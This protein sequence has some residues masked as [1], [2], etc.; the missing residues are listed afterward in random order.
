MVVPVALGTL[1]D[2]RWLLSWS[3]ALLRGAWGPSAP[4][5]QS[6]TRCTAQ[7][8][9]TSEINGMG[10]KRTGRALRGHC[11]EGMVEV[12]GRMMVDG[13]GDSDAV[14]ALQKSVCVSWINR[15]FPERCA[16]FDE[17]RWRVLSRNIP[18]QPMHF[19]IDRFE[20]PNRR[21]A[22]PWILVNWNEAKVIC[23]REAKRLCTEAESRP[24]RDVISTTGVLYGRGA[25]AH[26]KCR[27]SADELKH[28]RHRQTSNWTPSCRLSGR[29]CTGPERSV[30]GGRRRRSEP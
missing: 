5:L 8:P 29:R 6:A 30:L 11:A 4:A 15:T 16:Q 1:T 3:A 28:P 19:C 12:E 14:D 24:R 22:Y 26:S 23:A 21:G 10:R 17:E 13:W 2:L 7:P 27:T 25:K 9:A 18:T 20:Y